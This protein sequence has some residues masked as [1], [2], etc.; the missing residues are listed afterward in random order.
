[1]KPYSKIGILI[2]CMLSPV[3]N[4]FSFDYSSYKAERDKKSALAEFGIK[5][6]KSHKLR[7]PF[8]AN[9]TDDTEVSYS[10]LIL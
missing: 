6:A 1:M 4:G 5:Y 8:V 10:F 2:I 9:I 3:T 7:L